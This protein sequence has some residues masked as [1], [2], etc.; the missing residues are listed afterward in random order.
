MRP[1]LLDSGPLPLPT[2][3]RMRYPTPMILTAHGSPR[4]PVPPSPA[5][6]RR[7]LGGATRALALALV[8]CVSVGCGGPRDPDLERRAERSMKQFQ[9]DQA[10]RAAELSQVAVVPSDEIPIKTYSSDEIRAILAA[11]PGADRDL[12]VELRTQQGTITCRLDDAGAPQTVANF[13]GLATGQLPWRDGPRA[14]PAQRPFYDG[15]TFHRIVGNFIIQ[16]GNPGRRVGGGPGWTLPRET[17][18]DGLFDRPGVIAMVDAGELSHGSQFF[19]TVRPA[20][21]L[22]SRYAAFGQCEPIELIKAIAD[23]DKVPSTD[24][25]AP[26]VPRNPV[27]IFSAQVSRGD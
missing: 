6:W 9:Q 17:A 21:N 5:P 1:T 7:I 13:V 11:V 2:S 8:I 20:P 25:K 15:L 18:L 16:A 12:V 22:K 19:I 26:T 27:R 24:G 10:Q 4:S 3:C 14:A 23:A